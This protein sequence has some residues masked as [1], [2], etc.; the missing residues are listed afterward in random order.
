MH[1][2]NNRSADELANSGVVKQKNNRVLAYCIKAKGLSNEE[3]VDILSFTDIMQKWQALAHYAQIFETLCNEERNEIGNSYFSEEYF[4]K[5]VA[6]A[7]TYFAQNTQGPTISR[8]LL[9]LYSSINTVAKA[10]LKTLPLIPAI[11]A[12]LCELLEFDSDEPAGPELRIYI[13]YNPQ[14]EEGFYFYNIEDHSL[15][16]DEK[17]F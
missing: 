11:A 14:F 9:H 17:I 7:F 1:N 4:G 6:Q 16:F 2:F 3:T 8:A 12:A 10:N 13:G 15:K 5:A